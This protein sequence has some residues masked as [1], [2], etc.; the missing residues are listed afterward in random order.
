LLR[1]SLTRL[2]AFALYVIRPTNKLDQSGAAINGPL[3]D[4]AETAVS[5]RTW[6]LL[7]LV[8]A[9]LVVGFT[10]QYVYNPMPE[11]N[12]ISGYSPGKPIP[13]KK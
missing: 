12:F 13:D 11:L 1:A 9:A 8:I 6:F 2:A 7:L 10:I 4:V 5:R 3:D